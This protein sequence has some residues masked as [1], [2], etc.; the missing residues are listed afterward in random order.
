MKFV[1]MGL[2]EN[3]KPLLTVVEKGDGSYRRWSLVLAMLNRRLLS[4]DSTRYNLPGH[5]FDEQA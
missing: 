5:Y 2:G 4:C 1:S 3:R